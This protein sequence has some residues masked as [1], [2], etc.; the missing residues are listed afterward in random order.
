MRGDSFFYLRLGNGHYHS[1]RDDEWREA[2][3]GYG[4]GYGQ[5]VGDGGHGSGFGGGMFTLN[6]HWFGNGA[7]Y[8]YYT[9]AS[10]LA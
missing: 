7:W 2:E 3:Y 4:D 9:H 1:D 5:C 10:D 8:G 6:H